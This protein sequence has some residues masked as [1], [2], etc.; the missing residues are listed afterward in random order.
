MLNKMDRGKVVKVKMWPVK[1]QFSFDFLI[2]TFLMSFGSWS[3]RHK[4]QEL[5]LVEFSKK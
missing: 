3:A 4:V 5:Y 1:K 2:E